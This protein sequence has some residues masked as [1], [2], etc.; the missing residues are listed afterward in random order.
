MANLL[1]Q[2]F[3]DPCGVGFTITRQLGPVLKF[4]W[5]PTPTFPEKQESRPLERTNRRAI[6]LHM[7]RAVRNRAQGAP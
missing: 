6:P 3:R 5:N 2:C 4:L 7:D 1:H